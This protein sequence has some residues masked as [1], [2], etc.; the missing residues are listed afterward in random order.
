MSF[1]QEYCLPHLINCACGMKAIEKQRSKVVPL[2]QGDVLEVGMGSGL[3]LRH[4]DKSKIDKLWGLEP[5]IGM[6]RK[7]QSNIAN[8]GINVDWLELPSEEIP[9]ESGSV[10]TIVLTYTLCTIADTASALSEMS[11]VLKPSGK[12]LFSE[13]GLSPDASVQKWQAR[14]NPI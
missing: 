2:A 4:Y 13:H 11:R 3:N 10:D 7:A 6:R 14:V 12:L 8:S 5:S 9:L 1:Y